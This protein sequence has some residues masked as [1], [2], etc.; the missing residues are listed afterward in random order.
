MKKLKIVLKPEVVA[1]IR[2][3]DVDRYAI[4]EA[5]EMARLTHPLVKWVCRKDL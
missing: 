2:Q 1:V 5:L 4:K 3:R